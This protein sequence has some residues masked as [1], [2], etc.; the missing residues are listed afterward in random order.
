M[1]AGTPL[2]PANASGGLPAATLGTATF[3]REASGGPGLKRVRLA[4]GGY[5]TVPS[6]WVTDQEP[7]V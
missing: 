7:A 5:M 3:E 2:T 1:G 6:T 4:T